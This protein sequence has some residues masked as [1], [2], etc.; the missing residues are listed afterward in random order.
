MKRSIFFTVLL[1]VFGCK[2]E[3][4]N[5]RMDQNLKSIKISEDAIDSLASKKIFFGHMSV[6]YNILSGV[7][8]LINS[9]E[10]FNEIKIVELSEK[11]EITEPG[12]YHAKNGKNSF[13]ETKCD[14]F[15]NRLIKDDFGKSLDIA[16]FKF[17]YVDL[18]D[19]SDVQS[20]FNKYVATIDEIKS[21]FPNLKII[22]VTVP[23]RTHVWGIKEKIKRIIKSDIAN[24][25]RNE[26][27]KM[28]VEKY[29]GK[30]PI[31]DLAKVESTLPDG[32]RSSFK[33]KGE[34]IYILSEK[35]TYDGGHLNDSGSLLAGQELLQI[36]ADVS[37]QMAT[38]NQE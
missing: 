30:D 32:S 10:Q 18:K 11:F 6:G 33:H 13:P 5:S 26:F 23:L 34:S 22:H 35:Y 9:D 27:N 8:K 20:V 36:L 3:M 21:Q 12:L 15:K 38:E 31:F 1:L 4:E 14:A 37:T 28:L 25:K 17:C 24:V 19:N 2:N 7:E 16:F 29:D